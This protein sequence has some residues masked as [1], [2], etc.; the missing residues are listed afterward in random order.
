VISVHIGGEIPGRGAERLFNCFSSNPQKQHTVTLDFGGNYR[1]CRQRLNDIKDGGGV[2]VQRD[3]VHIY[4]SSEMPSRKIVSVIIPNALSVHTL[5]TNSHY[6][7]SRILA[8]F[9]AAVR[10]LVSTDHGRHALEYICDTGR[11]KA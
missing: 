9:H 1:G 5:V 10:E 3:L 7:Q 6:D 4:E 2:Q 8:R 11:Q